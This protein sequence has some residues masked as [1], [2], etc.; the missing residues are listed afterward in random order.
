[1]Q[2]TDVAEVVT[3]PEDT[4]MVRKAHCSWTIFKA[5]AR[6]CL[7]RDVSDTPTLMEKGRMRVF[8]GRRHDDRLFC[9][10]TP[11]ARI[12]FS[13]ILKPLR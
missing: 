1:M 5:K 4:D 10:P 13:A 11:V 6:E 2:T 7:I 8:Q 3:P 12:V 9:Q